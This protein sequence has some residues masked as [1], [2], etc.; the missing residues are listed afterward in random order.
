MAIPALSSFEH[1]EGSQ[2]AIKHLGTQRGLG[3]LDDTW[4]LGHSEGT[5]RALGHMRH[6]SPRAVRALGH[7]GTWALG[8]SGSQGTW[9]VKAL[10]LADSIM[11]HH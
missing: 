8:H 7:L 1:S 3:Y 9:A 10:Y 5:R 11:S 6:S 2:R 4:V